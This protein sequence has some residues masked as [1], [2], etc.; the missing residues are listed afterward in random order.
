M[1]NVSH[2]VGYTNYKNMGRTLYPNLDL[3]HLA[4]F[5]RNLDDIFIEICRVGSYQLPEFVIPCRAYR[6]VLTHETKSMENLEAEEDQP[7]L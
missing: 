6:G 3:S 5:G 1:F 2:S 4:P 7:P